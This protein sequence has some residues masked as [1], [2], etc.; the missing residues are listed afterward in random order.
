[1]IEAADAQA[2]AKPSAKRGAQLKNW[3]AGNQFVGVLGLLVCLFVVFSFVEPRF[4][5]AANIRVMLAGVASYG[6]KRVQARRL[7]P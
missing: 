7:Q 2:P 3:S 4:F 1:L 5:T 6:A